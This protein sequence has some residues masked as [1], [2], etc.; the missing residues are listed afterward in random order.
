[1]RL[2]VSRTVENYLDGHY[3][4]DEINNVGGTCAND[5]D[6]DNEDDDDE[7]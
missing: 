1:M 5:D 3:N 4:C 7:K 2:T 6:D